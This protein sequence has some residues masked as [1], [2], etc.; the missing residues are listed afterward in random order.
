M[1]NR[2]DLLSQMAIKMQQPVYYINQVGSYTDIIFDGG[3]MVFN[4]AGVLIHQL[5]SFEEDQLL[6]DLR[7][8]KL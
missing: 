3:S 4:G 2:K 5:K 8:Q 1:E 7:E 6:I